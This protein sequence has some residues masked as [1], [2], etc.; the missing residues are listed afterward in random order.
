MRLNS[1]QPLPNPVILGISGSGFGDVLRTV[2]YGLYLQNTKGY[3]VSLYPVCHGYI[4]HD[5]QAAPRAGRLD[6]CREIAAAFDRIQPMKIL[7]RAPLEQ[8]VFSWDLL[9]WHFPYQATRVRWSPPPAGGYRRV[10]CQFDGVWN[11]PQKNPP[12]EE[13]ERLLSGVPGYELVRLGK[14]LSVAK[15]IE[16]LATSDFFVGIDSGL[17]QLAYSAGTPAFLLPY[18]QTWE[19]LFCWH[20]DKGAVRCACAAEFLAKARFFLGMSA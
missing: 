11:A 16:A 13:L 5:F 8:V 17:M 14:H 19:P 10:T 18:S 15:N 4:H 12:P 7:D 6:L 2:Q 1:K 3:Q 9:P 20:G